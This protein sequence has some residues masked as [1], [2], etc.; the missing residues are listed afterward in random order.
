ML[1]FSILLTVLLGYSVVSAISVNFSY[2]EKIGSSFLLGIGIQVFG[3][4]I[5]DFINI[6]IKLMPIYIL[7]F[8]VI[9]FC[10]F[11][12][13]RIRKI[14]FNNAIWPYNPFEGKP[15]DKIN[16]PWIALMGFVVYTLWVI[17][18]KCLFW[19]TFEFDS[20]AGYDLAAK[21][22]AAEGSFHNSLF[23]SNGISMYNMSLR[24]VYPPLVSGSFAYAYMSGAELSKVITSLYYG[25]FIILFYG[26]L[27]RGNLTHLGT[28][29][30]VLLTMYVPEL[31]SHAALSQTNMPQ[32]VYTSTGFI[33]LF[34]WMVDK[35][36]NRD[37][38]F[39]SMLILSCNSII[40]SENIIFGFVAG[41]PVLAYTLRN[42][43][44]KNLIDLLI[45]GTVLLFPF[46][47]WS[48]YLKMEG[49][50]PAAFENGLS[51]SFSYDAQKFKDWWGL[52]WGY[53]QYPEGIVFNENFYALTPH[54]YVVSCFIAIAYFIFNFLSAQNEVKRAEQTIFLRKELA[55]LYIS[56]VPFLLYSLFFYLI[57]YDWDTIRNVMLFSYKR[58]LFAVMILACTFIGL[59]EPFKRSFQFIGN[60]M[61]PPK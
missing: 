28:A 42:R 37:F 31:T 50:K 43:T 57:N 54:L 21:V 55:L 25:S 5:M 61:Y 30:I 16:L 12:I 40:R 36:K 35:E 49:L 20:V 3:M 6:P 58:G 23:M 41:I 44:K 34:H 14:S 51:L 8:L 22:V 32:A 10:W 47:L 60:F 2:L 9:A 7:S 17:T 11:Y 19:P 29:F 45:F 39:L 24:A 46:V 33:A 38:L 4:I 1:W 27:R 26:L 53:K 18:I 56:L 48:V 59:S 52:L 15:W 13:L